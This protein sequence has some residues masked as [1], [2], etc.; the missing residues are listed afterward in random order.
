LA[1]KNQ[2]VSGA[3]LYSFLNHFYLLGY[4]LGEEEGVVLSLLH[5][6]ISQFQP[7]PQLIWSRVVD[8]VHTLN[9][10]AGTITLDNLPED[11]K[12]FFNQPIVTRIPNELIVQPEQSIVNW[13]QHPHASAIALVNLIGAWNDHNEA[14]VEFVR[15][16]MKID[17]DEWISQARE[18]LQLNDSPFFLE[19]GIWKVKN[20]ALFWD[21]LGAHIL[22]Q[23]LDIFKQVVVS[24]MTEDDPA[25]ELAPQQRFAANLYGKVSIYSS[26]LRKGLA[27]SL[28]LLGV[29]GNALIHCSTNKAENT[30]ILAIREIFDNAGWELWGS[31]NDLLPVIAE[32]A[33]EEFLTAVENALTTVFTRRKWRQW[34]EL[35][36]GIT[37][38]VRRDRLG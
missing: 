10:D 8:M 35:F 1:N 38:G 19:N 30:V 29:R 25:F 14:D 21:V 24:V 18:L 3:E 5:S 28:A 7:N 33:P 37:V 26:A 20:R 12:D 6:H 13:R 34:K 17:H 36:N 11:L 27:D 22:D 32:A 23:D 4:D 16:M 2:E 15:V 31:L 9:K